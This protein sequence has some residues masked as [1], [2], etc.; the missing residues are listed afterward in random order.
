MSLL[1]WLLVAWASFCCWP[2]GRCGTGAAHQPLHCP[3]AGI[4]RRHAPAALARRARPV[5][6]Q[7]GIAGFTGRA[8]GLAMRYRA[9]GEPQ[10][11]MAQPDLAGRAGLSDSLRW[12]DVALHRRA[13]G[14]ALAVVD[15]FAQTWLSRMRERTRL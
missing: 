4:A 14:L 11:P 6:Q 5:L 10:H 12:A 2:P 13:R 15:V 3:V 8:N 1:P 7:A 9:M